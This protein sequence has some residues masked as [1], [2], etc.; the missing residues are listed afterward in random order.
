MPFSHGLWRSP[1][2]ERHEMEGHGYPPGLSSRGSLSHSLNEE[3]AER[4]RRQIVVLPAC[5]LVHKE[6]L[7]TLTWYFLIGILN[8]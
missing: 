8:C 6:L 7:N 2:M 3:P 5:P 4:P 1:Q